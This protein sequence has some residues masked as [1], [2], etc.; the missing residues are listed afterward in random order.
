[1]DRLG[2]GQ[3]ESYCLK[4]GDVFGRLFDGV[5][6]LTPHVGIDCN[7]GRRATFF[8]FRFWH[9]DQDVASF[10][11]TQIASLVPMI[12]QQSGRIGPNCWCSIV[13][14]NP[15]QP[16]RAAHACGEFL[17]TWRSPNEIDKFWASQTVT[18]AHRNTVMRIFRRG[19][20]EFAHGRATWRWETRDGRVRAR[21]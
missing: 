1:M 19:W 8:H 12:I 6:A 17:H 13:V 11:R 3:L 15:F 4:I 7:T 21:F 10:L 2:A 18:R 5:D 16:G 9:V 20:K 14:M